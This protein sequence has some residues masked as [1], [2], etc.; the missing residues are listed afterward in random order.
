ML[1]VITACVGKGKDDRRGHV[2]I[3]RISCHRR[4]SGMGF[5]RKI[6]LKWRELKNI[7]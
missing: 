3:T 5:G 2:C 6:G 1:T 7:L 4:V